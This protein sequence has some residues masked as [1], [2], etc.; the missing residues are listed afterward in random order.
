MNKSIT[1]SLNI[2]QLKGLYSGLADTGKGLTNILNQGHIPPTVF[3][4]NI[5]MNVIKR[6]RNKRI[7]IWQ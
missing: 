2:Q 5:L 6:R 7:S 4:T 3:H 1:K